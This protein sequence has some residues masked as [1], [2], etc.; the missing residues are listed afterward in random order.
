MQFRTGWLFLVSTM[1]LFTYSCSKE[2]AQNTSVSLR[3]NKPVADVNEFIYF[4]FDG[5][6]DFFSFYN[7]RTGREFN[8]LPNARGEIRYSPGDTIWVRYTE[9]GNYKA[10]VVA[11]SYGNWGNDMQM[12][13]DSL[14]IEVQ[15]NDTGISR[16]RMRRPVGQNGVLD[17]DRVTFSFSQTIDL[18]NVEMQV[19]TNSNGAKVFPNGDESLAPP[20]PGAAFTA[21]FSGPDPHFIVE[22]FSGTRKKYQL[23]FNMP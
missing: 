10:T 8:K 4:I 22:S 6:A 2:P 15:D 3:V 19:F 12:A 13:I 5:S 18:S 9:F 20:S 11:T 14:T 23:I 21:D 17:E 7:G 16:V 1:L